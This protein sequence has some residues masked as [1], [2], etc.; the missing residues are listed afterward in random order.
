MADADLMRRTILDVQ[1]RTV[2]E[3]LKFN[4]AGGISEVVQT[5]PRTEAMARM[6]NIARVSDAEENIF[7]D[8][9]FEDSN[10]KRRDLHDS[11]MEMRAFRVLANH[12]VEGRYGQLIEGQIMKTNVLPPTG[13]PLFDNEN[14]IKVVCE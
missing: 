7:V 3:V 12:I 4:K 1:K 8:L 14:G 6:L 2:F 11:A 13:Q 5:L 10:G 9:H